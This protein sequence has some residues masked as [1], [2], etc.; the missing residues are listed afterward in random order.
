MQA[1]MLCWEISKG[2]TI[3]PHGV[4][5]VQVQEQEP[6][7]TTASQVNAGACSILLAWVTGHQRTCHMHPFP[8]KMPAQFN[9]SLVACAPAAAGAARCVHR[10]QT[11]LCT[12]WA[13]LAGPAGPDAHISQ[14]GTCA[15]RMPSPSQGA[16]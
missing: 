12:V 5:Q 4:V 16:V 13:S 11:P 14:I 6:A 7:R 9:S 1:R 8:P 3:F 15:L 2:M 10:F